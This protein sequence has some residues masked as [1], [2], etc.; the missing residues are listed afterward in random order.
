MDA[1]QLGAMFGVTPIVLDLGNTGIQTSSAANGVNFDLVGAGQTQQVGWVTGNSGL[2]AMDLNADGQIN[3][4]AELFGVGTQLAGGGHAANGYHALAQ[5]DANH[6]GKVSALDT[7]FKDLR[8]WVD[9]DHDAVTDAGELKSM[10]ELKIAELD[11]NASAS[12][13]LD[14]GNLLGL[15]SGYKTEDGLTH[16]MADVW[17]AKVPQGQEEPTSVADVPVKLYD[18]LAS[19][20]GDIMQAKSGDVQAAVAQQPGA[21]AAE[22]VPVA[23]THLVGLFERQLLRDDGSIAPPLI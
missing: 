12:T 2:L 20:S 6:D 23:A 4:G 17:F 3:N 11:L 5:L 13:Q 22:L 7:Q 14:N 16:Q 9:A 1:G 8:V 10:Q 15:I 19:A 21:Q 18:V